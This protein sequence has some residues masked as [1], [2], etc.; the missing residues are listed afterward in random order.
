MKYILDTTVCVA[1]IRGNKNVLNTIL[2]KGE[3]NCLVS[4]MTIAELYYGA[5]KS[6]RPSQFQ[7]VQYILDAFETVPVFSSLRTYGDIKSQLEASG[8]RID[9]FDLLIGATALTNSMVL[10]THN[11]K[12]FQRIPNL[13]LEDW[14]RT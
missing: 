11:T 14:E 12:H 1:L 13:K 6:G 7:D 9:E 2:E 10:V 4:E 5:S 3:K 8:M